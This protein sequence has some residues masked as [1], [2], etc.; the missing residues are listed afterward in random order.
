MS[1]EKVS[2][3]EP[4]SS[5]SSLLAPTSDS[6]TAKPSHPFK[7]WEVDVSEISEQPVSEQTETETEKTTSLPLSDEMLV[8]ES[9]LPSSSSSSTSSSSSSSS[10]LP[11]LCIVC[12]KPSFLRCSSCLG[13]FY[14]G[15]ECQKKA[16]PKHK[17]I[18]KLA[19]RFKKDQDTTSVEQ[20]DLHKEFTRKIAEEGSP[21]AQ[22]DLSLAYE[23]G[24]GYSIDMVESFKWCKKSAENGNTMARFNLSQKYR[25]GRG[26]SIDQNES[27]K[28]LKIVSESG[29]IPSYPYIADAYLN[30]RGVEKS[31]IEAFNWYKKGAEGN[32]IVSQ[33]ELG[34]SYF[35]G[36]GCL[37]DQI[38]AVKWYTKAAEAGQA[39][40]MSNLGNC[41]LQGTGVAINIDK[42]LEWWIKA[43]ELGDNDA[44]F[45]AGIFTYSGSHG[46]T[47][48]KIQGMKWMKLSAAKGNVQAINALSLISNYTTVRSVSD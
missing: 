43:A 27:L 25:L 20:D 16:W 48:D 3:T 18:C 30:G 47:K 34:Y 12:T 17:K 46:I 36:R 28:W 35:T 31:L 38:E 44:Q 9:T 10:S 5:P 4:T 8:K 1:H 11:P 2:E 32:D 40:A 41:Y 14:C 24:M 39:R 42:A 26:V 22:S 7:Y 13:A 15:Q 19:E 33:A 21:E 6:V 29:D 45:Q 23:L 37:V